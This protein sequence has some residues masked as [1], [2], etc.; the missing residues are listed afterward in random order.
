MPKVEQVDRDAVG[1]WQRASDHAPN[2]LAKAFAAHRTAAEQRG[3]DMAIAEV[4]AWLQERNGLAADL[5]DAIEAG[6]HRGG[7]AI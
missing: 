6:E 3:Y 5:G 1:E 4:V 2:K 7:E